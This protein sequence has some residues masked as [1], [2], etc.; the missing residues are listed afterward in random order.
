MLAL[1]RREVNVAFPFQD[2]DTRTH[3]HCILII[4]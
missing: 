4:S 3:A 2:L 1:Q